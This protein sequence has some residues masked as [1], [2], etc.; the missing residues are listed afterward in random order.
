MNSFAAIDFET[1]NQARSSVC[2][3]G[4]VVVKNG[5]IANTYYH[6]IKPEPNFYS[7]WNVRVHG[8]TK[9]DTQDAPI[10][11]KVWQEI[12]PLIEDLPL[13][14]HNSPFDEGCLKAAFATYNLDYPDYKFY[15]TLKASR[16]ILGSKLENHKLDTVASFLGFDLRN[17]HHALS[18]AQACAYIALKLFS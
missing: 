6:L 10:F 18:D 9:E 5:Q 15:C 1:A 7:Y 13:V 4:V 17:H 14:A 16:K 3:V 11:P 2:S 8:I 12:E